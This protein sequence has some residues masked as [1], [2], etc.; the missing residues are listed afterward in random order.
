MNCVCYYIDVGNRCMQENVRTKIAAGEETEREGKLLLYRDPDKMPQDK[1]SPGQNAT[2]QNVT[3]TKCHPDK[4]PQ[5]KMS[6]GQNATGHN[7]LCILQCK[8]FLFVY[9]IKV[10]CIL[11]YLVV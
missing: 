6:H 11:T 10:S 7:I 5:D 9:I 1:M 3:R 8:H 2:G 4:M